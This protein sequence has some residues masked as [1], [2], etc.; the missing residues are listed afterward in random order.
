LVPALEESASTSPP[1]TSGTITKKAVV[2]DPKKKHQEFNAEFFAT[3]TSIATPTPLWVALEHWHKSVT[4]MIEKDPG[5]P[6]IEQLFITHLL[7]Q[8]WL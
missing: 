4:V 5:N 1:K 3:V 8:G 7:L 2:N 6:R